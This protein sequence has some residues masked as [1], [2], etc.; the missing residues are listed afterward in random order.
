MLSYQHNR[1]IINESKRLPRCSRQHHV[2]FCCL[3]GI[4]TPFASL[5]Q[6][7]R[8]LALVAPFIDAGQPDAE[9]HAPVKSVRP[10]RSIIIMGLVLD[11]YS[12]CSASVARSDATAAP[13]LFSLS[14]VLVQPSLRPSMVLRALMIRSSSSRAW[15]YIPNSVINHVSFKPRCCYLTLLWDSSLCKLITSARSVMWSEVS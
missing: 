13:F 3:H 2:L 15:T 8:L 4:C 5:S 7:L 6:T 10:Y 1:A 11:L 9:E 12:R 14:R